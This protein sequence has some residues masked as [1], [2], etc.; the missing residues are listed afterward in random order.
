MMLG[1][2]LA[3]I[4]Q[5]LHQNRVIEWVGKYPLTCYQRQRSALLI[6]CPLAVPVI[7]SK[8]SAVNTESRKSLAR[9][10]AHLYRYLFRGL[11]EALLCLP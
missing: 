6:D 1:K 9:A 10:S 2:G 7:T 5:C 11:Q 8:R 4:Q 3:F